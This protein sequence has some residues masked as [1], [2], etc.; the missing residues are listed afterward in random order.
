VSWRAA[1]GGAAALCA[2]LLFGPPSSALPADGEAQGPG[3]GCASSC[4]VDARPHAPLSER[5]LRELLATWSEEG[6]DRESLALDTLLF[7]GSETAS[8][9][10]THPELDLAPE[11]RSWL[12]AQLARDAVR[13]EFRL[14]DDSG[15]TRGTVSASGVP[16]VQK[17]HLRFEGTGSLGHFEASGKVKRVGLD[18]LWS[19]W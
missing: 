6:E 19:R 4:S 18:H 2:A 8:F 15:R 10:E 11:R 14:I 7:H 13:V 3:A 5:R 1:L 17:Q 9:L 16:L 12:R